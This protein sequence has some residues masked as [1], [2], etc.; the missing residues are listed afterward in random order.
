MHRR[1]HDASFTALNAGGTNTGHI[2]DVAVLTADD[3]LLA[4]L[5]DAVGTEHALWHAPSA[6]AAVDLLVGGRCG[7]LIVDLQ[8]IAR[9]DAPALLER[10]QSQFPE[11]VLLAT[12][13]REEEGAV[14]G[15]ISKGCVY[16]FLHKPV[17]P[18]RAS[19]FLAAATRRYY[20][21]SDNSSPPLATGRHLAQPSH[22]IRLIAGSAA[23]LIFI[24]AVALI[25]SRHDA[26]PAANATPAQP[27]VSPA[28]S[29]D[30][31]LAAAQAALGAGRLSPPHSDNAL[32]HY[33]AVLSVQADNAVALAGVRQILDSLATQVTTALQNRDA[34]AANHALMTLQAAQPEHPQLDALRT[35]LLALS[36]SAKPEAPA[37]AANG[38]TPA[39]KS[40]VT[41][42]RS[43]PNIALARSR[44]TS[45][46]FI[47][48]AGDSAL[49]YLQQAHDQG[50]DES[51]GKILATDLGTKVL[52]QAQQAL[53]A[54]DVPQAQRLMTAAT[55]IDREF[56]L[57][58][59]DLPAVDRQVTEQLALSSR[60]AAGEQFN[61]QLERA[62][63]LR[64]DSQLIEPAGN[65]AYDVLNGIAA[66]NADA[67]EVRAER[68]RLVFALLENTRTA[69]AASDLDRADALITRADRLVPGMTTTKTLQEQLAAA[70]EEHA[71]ASRV[72]QA[73][74][75]KR[76]RE[77]PAAYPRD[78][79]RDG[80]QGWV[81]VDFTIA[82]DGSTQGLV[83][84][85]AQ[86][87]GMFD[88]AALE[89]LRKWRFEPVLRNGA[90]V[91]QRA[92]LRMKFVLE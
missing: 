7:I 89:A 65:N 39:Q 22:R 17:S 27:A 90:P 64:E 6:D 28:I 47:E 30:E 82:A 8:L 83:V 63:K 29:I 67:P 21:L 35:Q 48:P 73:A 1:Q 84:R 86:P 15:L 75:L 25:W 23:V 20:E 76:T 61:D 88:D 14:A 85:D 18:A 9:S 68:Q 16:R 54:G 66:E 31:Q 59:P 53:A 32:T 5:Q 37:A 51:A 26:Q 50:E 38:H 74:T 81:D 2:V 49:S 36:R 46:Q 72:V 79:E 56:E 4:T 10:L 42:T 19:L 69:L 11:L 78:A 33:R 43:A 40:A 12:G 92:T 60:A 71:A 45:G 34:P 13:R 52:G 87:K 3:S 62:I 44:I 58:L 80:T 91:E 55:Q 24:L 57:G 77:V 70:R 41:P